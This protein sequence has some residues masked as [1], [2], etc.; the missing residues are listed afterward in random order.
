MPRLASDR[1]FV[2]SVGGILGRAPPVNKEGGARAEALTVMLSQEDERAAATSA[3][4]SASAGAA[5][6]A[7]MLAERGPGAL[8]QLYSTLSDALAD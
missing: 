2:P 5:K 8:Q 1:C 6:V 4:A 7:K 3:A